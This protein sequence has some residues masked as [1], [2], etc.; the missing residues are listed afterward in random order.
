MKRDRNLFV[1]PLKIIRIISRYDRTYLLWSALVIAIS[2]VIPLLFVYGPKMILDTLI[3][4]DPFRKTVITIA[5]FGGLLLLLNTLNSF[6]QSK[7]AV[8][9][10]RF[11]RKMQYDLGNKVMSLDL[12]RLEDPKTANTIQLAGDISSITNTVSCVSTILSGIITIAGLSYAVAKLDVGCVISVIVAVILKTVISRFQLNRQKAVRELYVDNDRVGNYLDGVAYFS[13]GGTKEIRVNNAQGWFMSKV[14]G[15]RRTMVNLQCRDFAYAA[16]MDI[17]LTLITSLQTFLVLAFTSVRTINGDLSLAEFTMVFSA[18]LTLTSAFASFG[19][20]INQYRSQVLS[21]NDYESLFE[22]SNSVGGETDPA[23]KMPI[24]PINECEIVFDHVCFTYNNSESFALKDVCLKIKDKEKLVIV[25]L[26]GSGKSTLIK[27][28]CKFYKPTGGRITLNGV[29]IWSI[30]N[31]E[32]YQYIAAVFQDYSIFAF[33]ILENVTMR[34]E[35]ADHT[36]KQILYDVGLT[37]YAEYPET[38]VSK[39]FSDKG[40]ELSGGEGQKLSIARA[41][42]KNASV[43]I[44]D[45]PTSS[46]DIKAEAEIYNN[47]YK[48]AKDKT[49]IFVSHRLACST[50]ADNIAVFRNGEMVEYG[51]HDHLLRKK[52]LYAEMYEK[53]CSA[54]CNSNKRQ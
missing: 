11:S 1:S 36:V 25:G 33:S 21:V 54:Y 37:K 47:F 35:F 53:Q 8:S 44:L 34:E 5:V 39:V 9:S 23:D 20:Q 27:L 18:A 49:T 29:D 2:A 10:S 26:N 40:I 52:G 43:L 14:S 15:F 19:Q 3:N 31:R 12:C 32:Y 38:V 22:Y 46:L 45:E 17:L 6:F 42:Y 30:D 50:V 51:S 16:K 7:Q 13:P 48:I 4:N 28:L 41:I 24:E